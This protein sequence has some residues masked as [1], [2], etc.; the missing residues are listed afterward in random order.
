M[1]R[2]TFA[3]GCF[4]CLEDAVCQLEGVIDTIVGYTGG[5]LANPTYQD[6]CS[7]ITGHAEAVRVSYD[8][9]SICYEQ[10]LDVFW[11]SHDPTSLNRQGANVGPQ[12]RSA[13]FY[14]NHYQKV[15][16]I[17]SRRHRQLQL[18]NSRLIITEIVPEGVF[19]PAEEYHQN[20]FAKRKQTKYHL[21]T[22]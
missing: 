21:L 14:S 7:G 4:W 18:K 19:Y 6:I 9:D 8:P 2:A 1:E 16:A 10:L 5:S 17:E 12:Y 22:R 3:A 15:S 20:Y 11:Q 13:I